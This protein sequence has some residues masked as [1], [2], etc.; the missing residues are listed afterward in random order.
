MDDNVNSAQ[1]FRN[2]DDT[3]NSGFGDIVTDDKS[4]RVKL[5]TSNTMER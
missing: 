1:Y 2:T 4:L 5:T 3:A